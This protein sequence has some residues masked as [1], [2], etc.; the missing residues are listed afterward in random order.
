ML[1][2]Y[3]ARGHVERGSEITNI[4]VTSLKSSLDDLL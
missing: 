3:V 2:I 1:L 4:A